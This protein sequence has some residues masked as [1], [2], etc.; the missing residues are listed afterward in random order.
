MDK[1]SRWQT[2]DIFLFFQRKQNL[3][4]HANCLPENRIWYF[5]Q[6]VSQGDSLH[7]VDSCFLGEN[8]KSINFKMLSAEIFTQ[9]AKY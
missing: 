3:P 7:D 2:D 5:M 6:T 8:K 9:H 4:V 1:F